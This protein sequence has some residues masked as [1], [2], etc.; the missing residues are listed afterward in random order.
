MDYLELAKCY[1]N[2][3]KTT[4]RLE[5]TEIIAELI[6][7]APKEV[8][9]QIMYLINGKVFPI[10]DERKIGVSS[11][12]AIKALAQT[13]GTSAEKIESMMKKKGDLGLVAEEL[14]QTNKQKTLFSKKLT[15]AKVFE[16]IS[17][18]AN[19]QGQG[20]VNR[21]VQLI[22]ELYSNASPLEARYITR[23]LL[24]VLRV[25]VAEGTIRD[26]L[27]WA[28]FPKMVSYDKEKQEIVLTGSRDEYNE[29][30]DK[31]QHAYNMSNDFSE[32]AL[33]LKE[34]KLDSLKKIKISLA[35]P[36]NPML[37][38]KVESIKEAYEILG[39]KVLWEYKLDGF[40]GQIHKLGKNKYEIYTRRL[41]KVTNQFKELIPRLEKHVKGDSYILDTEFVGY[42][43]KTKRPRPFQYISQRIKRKHNIEKVAK[44]FPVEINVFDVLYLDGK[45]LMDLSQIERRKILE[46]IIK[47]E[48]FNIILTK[49][50]LTENQKE[51]EKFYKESLKAG[52]E[53]LMGK[54]IEKDYK[55]GRHVN[56]WI[57][58]KPIKE[59]LDLVITGAQWG[60]GKR[61]SAFSSFTLSCR[62]D[63]KFLEVGKVGTGIKEKDAELTFESLTKL[64]K[65]LILKQKNQSAEIKPRLVVEVNYEEIQKSPTYSSGYALRFPRVTRIRYDKSEKNANTV[66]DVKRIYT[67]QNKSLI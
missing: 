4:K 2:L 30:M 23:T 19:M 28:F 62:S 56:G 20:T 31:I 16:N 25:G 3:E 17:N 64:L 52:N 13:T 8:L 24:D 61:T 53:G 50:L 34:N 18:L 12:I 36:I 1:D 7:K 49:S 40:R 54:Q 21:R 35:K 60:E 29:L 38:I 43:P 67:K 14:I 27:L 9:K 55:P 63:G 58:L 15:I 46:K 37:A 39:K 10:Y 57:K 44:E 47:E 65:P 66:E 5:K 11:K 42:D 26:S 32:I 41:E 45:N 33:A 22:S 6:K 51:V 48:K 59:P